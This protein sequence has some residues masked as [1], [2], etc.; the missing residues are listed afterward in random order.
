VATDLETT[1]AGAGGV[2]TAPWAARMSALALASAAERAI[3]LAP[4]PAADAYLEIARE[5]R[6]LALALAQHQ[7]MTPRPKD[8]DR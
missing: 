2:I 3:V 7:A 1:A 4:G 5:Y 6:A 8:D